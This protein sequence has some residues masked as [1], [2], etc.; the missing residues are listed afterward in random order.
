MWDERYKQE[1]Y[2]YGTKPNDFLKE[3]VSHIKPQGKV[4]CLGEG[5]GRN[6]LF[7]MQS[8]FHVTAVDLSVEGKKKAQKLAKENGFDLDYKVENLEQFDLG[9]SEW[10]AIVSIYCHLPSE[11]RKKVHQKIIN[12]LRPEGV[13]LLEGYSQEQLNYK[14]GGPP[15]LD[16]LLTSNEFE[17]DFKEFEI[18][19]N[20]QLTRE[21][22]EGTFHTGLASVIQFIGMK[23]ESTNE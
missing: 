14:T 3:S 13:F 5:E 18:K 22:V 11:L 4:L 15:H 6:A 20:E 10:D 21:V 16:M 12:A 9:K 17:D 1:D 19:K 7:L 23:K 8:G 2:V